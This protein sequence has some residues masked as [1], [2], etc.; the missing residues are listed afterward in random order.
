MAVRQLFYHKKL[1]SVTLALGW[2]YSAYSWMEAPV[3]GGSKGNRLHYLIPN[4]FTLFMKV[5]FLNVSLLANS[6]QPSLLRFILIFSKLA[7]T[8]P[9]SLVPTA[10]P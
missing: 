1:S 2:G 10:S 4:L 5:G 8:R 6:V 7:L 3:D 9:L